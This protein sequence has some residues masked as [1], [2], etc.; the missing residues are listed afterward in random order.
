MN[1][2]PDRARAKV[3]PERI[4][5]APLPGAAANAPAPRVRARPYSS[6][7]NGYR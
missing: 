5:L 1:A 2:K 7:M 4:N 6:P 3:R